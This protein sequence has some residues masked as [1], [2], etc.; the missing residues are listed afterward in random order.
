MKYQQVYDGQWVR[1]VMNG[2]R[3]MCCDCGL[4]HELDFKVIE[5]CL[6]ESLP[7]LVV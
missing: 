4:V 6:D 1:P 5:W 2:Y 7:Q 3:M